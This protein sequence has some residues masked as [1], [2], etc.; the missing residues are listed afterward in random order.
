MTDRDREPG[1]GRAGSAVRRGQDG[2]DAHRFMRTDQVARRAQVDR[3]CRCARASNGS[4][5]A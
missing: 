2:L 4:G 1:R 3:I 5:P